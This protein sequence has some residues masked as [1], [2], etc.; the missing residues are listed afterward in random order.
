VAEPEFLD[1]PPNEAAVTDY[2]RRHLKL[3]ARLLDAKVAGANWEEVFRILFAPGDEVA[4]ERAK[5]IHDSH[6]ERAEWMSRT[7]Y[8]DLTSEARH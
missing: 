8:H 6:L 2:D 1:E 7:G 5:R 4:P 3:Y